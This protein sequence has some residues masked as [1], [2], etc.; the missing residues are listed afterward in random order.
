MIDNLGFSR[1]TERS[2]NSKVN[3]YHDYIAE[4]FDGSQEMC[5]RCGMIMLQNEDDTVCILP[6]N[7]QGTL[8]SPYADREELQGEVVEIG[9]WLIRRAD[10]PIY[11]AY[12]QHEL[13]RQLMNGTTHGKGDGWRD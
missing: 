2:V 7:Q 10:K 13:I 11:R 3:L 5:Q 6:E 1:E 4:R 12:T 9:D 8:N